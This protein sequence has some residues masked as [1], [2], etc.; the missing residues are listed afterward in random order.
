MATYH[1]LVVL[2][3]ACMLIFL[4]TTT[5]ATST[6]HPYASFIHLASVGAWFGI[7]FWVTFVA[8]VLLFKYLP[9][10]QFGS[11]QGKIFPYY[12][13]LSL[14]LTSLALASWV[15]LE[16]GLDL[17]AAIKSG[18]EDGK[19]VA[20]LGGAALLSALQ[21]LVLGPCVTQAMEARNKKEKEEGFADTT[22]KVGRSPEL[23]QLGAAFA[24]MHGLSSSANLLVFL[25]ALFQL[26]VLSAKHVT[27]ATMAPTVAKATFWPWS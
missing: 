16:G 24:R 6:T 8:G 10:H 15:H 21:L 27:F 19:V 22:S 20:C 3:S 9:R 7:S 2:A 13:A 5:E 17:L 14:V 25:G 12:F 18:N 11:V 1:A 4:G 23:L 26:Y